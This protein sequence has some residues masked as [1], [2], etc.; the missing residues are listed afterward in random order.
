MVRSGAPPTQRAEWL[1]PEVPPRTT[2]ATLSAAGETFCSGSGVWGLRFGARE[3]LSTAPWPRL[4][5]VPG[6]GSMAS[7]GR[8]RKA[9][10]AAVSAAEKQE[11]L[12]GGQK[13]VEEATVVIEHW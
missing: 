8:K 3:G 9:E 4:H 1:C 11:K 13:E 7:R 10:A 12:A 5:P 2:C 6:P